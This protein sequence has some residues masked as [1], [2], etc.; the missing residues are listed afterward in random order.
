MHEGKLILG[1]DLFSAPYDSHFIL[2]AGHT[3]LIIIIIDVN[4]FVYF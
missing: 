3:I 4:K 2:V 1:G